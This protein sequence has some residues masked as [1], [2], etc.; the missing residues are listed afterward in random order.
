MKKVIACLLFSF[1][2]VNSYAQEEQEM[3]MSKQGDDET[4]EEPKKGFKKENL[5]IGGGVQL[6]F[7]SYEFGVGGSPVI[8]Y[9]L[10]KW[11]DVGA[12]VNV[13][14]ISQREAYI[15][16]YGNEYTTGNKIHQTTI[17]PLAFARF[18]PLKFLFVQAQGEHSFVSQKYIYA[19]N[20]PDDKAKIDVNSLLLGVG[21]ANGRQGVGDFYYYI[22]LSVDVLKN[23]YSPYVQQSINGDVNLLPIFKAGIQVPLFQ[24]RRNRY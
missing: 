23:R 2:A 13:S 5:F 1:L 4:T 14:Y 24:G 18:Y 22:S 7:S 20:A 15:D 17:A 16:S 12:G 11:L 8:G 19:T 10:N 9:S 6:S 3:R 21:Y